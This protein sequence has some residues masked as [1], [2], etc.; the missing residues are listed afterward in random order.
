MSSLVQGDFARATTFFTLAFG[1]TA[2]GGVLLGDLRVGI[3]WG[4]GL[5]AAFAVFAYFFVRPTADS[6]ADEA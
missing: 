5:G 6:T 4:L 1:L 3:R 2:L